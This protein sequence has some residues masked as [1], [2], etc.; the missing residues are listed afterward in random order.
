MAV[1]RKRKRAAWCMDV[2]RELLPV[3]C[4]HGNMAEE[5]GMKEAV[6]QL[7]RC[8]ILLNGCRRSEKGT[9]GSW[10]D[11]WKYMRRSEDWISCMNEVGW[12]LFVGIELLEGGFGCGNLVGR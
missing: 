2:A 10:M 9:P 3:S 4:W 8:R 12:E 6:A 11:G 1:S 7:C 5:G